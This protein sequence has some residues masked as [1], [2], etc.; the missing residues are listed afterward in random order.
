[1]DRCCREWS[2]VRRYGFAGPRVD[3]DLPCA[4]AI[5]NAASWRRRASLRTHVA[6]DVSAAGGRALG[7][8]PHAKRRPGRLLHSDRRRTD[9]WGDY[10]I[11]R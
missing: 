2:L 6:P 4:A 11:S 3:P 7:S 8:A 1:M 10:G 9:K 5:R